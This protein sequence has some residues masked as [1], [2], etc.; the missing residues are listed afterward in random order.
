MPQSQQLQALG[1]SWVHAAYVYKSQREARRVMLIRVFKKCVEAVPII[2]CTVKSCEKTHD[3]HT[4][5]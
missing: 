2:A 1:T 5:C 3:S 4:V